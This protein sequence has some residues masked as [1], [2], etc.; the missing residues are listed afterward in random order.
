AR[1][2]WLPRP[3]ARRRR[4]PALL[5]ARH[6]PAAVRR[7]RPLRQRPHAHQRPHPGRCLERG[8]RP[9]GRHRRPGHQVVGRRRRR[10]S[11]P[12]RPHGGVVQV[13]QAAARSR[14]YQGR[15]QPHAELGPPG[16]CPP[17]P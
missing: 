4:L 17:P 3:E 12:G 2:L 11:S 8:R 6:R 16:S 1:V 10:S 13:H 7:P 5:R 15:L 14:S 9:R